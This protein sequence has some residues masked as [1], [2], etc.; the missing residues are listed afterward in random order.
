MKKILVIEDNEHIRDNTAEI[1]Q[2]AQYRVYTAENGIKG[3]EAAMEFEPDLIVCD[4][5][6]P[7]LDGY[8]V[9]N[10]VHNNPALCNTPFIFLTAK[11][12]ASDFRKGMDMGADDYIPKPF[13]GT[14]LL[15]AIETRFKKADLIKSSFRQD[16]HEKE[17]PQIAT[18]EKQSLQQFIE[19]RNI[20]K[21]RKKQLIYT[22][23]NHPLRLYYIQKGKVKVFKRNDD[24]KELVVS[25]YKEGDFFGYIAL[26]EET[27]YKDS[28]EAMEECEIAVIP[29]Q[30]FDELMRTNHEAAHKFIKLLANDISQKEQHL[31]NIAYN[32]LRKKVADALIVMVE[33]YKGDEDFVINISRENLAAIAGTATESLIRTLSDFKLEKLIDIKDGNITILNYDKLKRMVN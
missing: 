2:L 6:M 31:L 14:D 9:L 26:L 21:Y 8:G 10:I 11:S 32:S 24:G 23:G 12:D 7:E 30:E 16:I 19:G 25:L 17:Q 1:L 22:E 3:V 20:D 28:A 29:K 4:I 15:H 13:S 18:S 33:K 5:M 27:A